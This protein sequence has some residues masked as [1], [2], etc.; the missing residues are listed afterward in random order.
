M[1]RHLTLVPDDYPPATILAPGL[2][3]PDLPPV[4][5]APESAA[6]DI[7]NALQMLRAVEWRFVSLA[8]LPGDAEYLDAFDDIQGRLED[9]LAKLEDKAAP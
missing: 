7:R 2:L 3:S 4:L 9:A 5:H 8:V 1:S 6:E